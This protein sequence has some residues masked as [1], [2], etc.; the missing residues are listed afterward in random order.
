MAT[1]KNETVEEVKTPTLEEMQAQMAQ[2]LAEAQAAKAEAA[3]MLEEAAKLSA[4]KVNSAERA[5]EIEAD[6]ARGEELVEVK[7]FKDTGK[8]KDDV[9]V[10]VNGENCVIQR[11]E[12][13][14]IKRKFAEVLDHSEHQDYETS[15][16]IEQKSREGAKALSE[17]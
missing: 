12:R 7:L 2:M 3:R 14:K 13:V 4:G 6:K 17:M 9:F 1:K 15:L 5:A 8:Y 16:M 11:G 10:G